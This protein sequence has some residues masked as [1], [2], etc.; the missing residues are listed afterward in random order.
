MYEEAVTIR[1]TRIQSY[2][3]EKKRK[4]R[5]ANINISLLYLMKNSLVRQCSC[6]DASRRRA[7]LGT[8]TKINHFFTL[9]TQ[10]ELSELACQANRL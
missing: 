2:E 1:K 6:A 9:Y 5:K 8:G 7:Q 10:R 3:N 4:E